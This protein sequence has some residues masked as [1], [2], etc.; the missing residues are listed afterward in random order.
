[1]VII[2]LGLFFLLKFKGGVTKFYAG[3][4]ILI[5]LTFLY[6]NFQQGVGIEI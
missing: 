1:M 6:F 2:T 3:V 4:L 5:Y